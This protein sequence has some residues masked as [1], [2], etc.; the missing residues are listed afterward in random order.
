MSDVHSWCRRNVE[1][2]DQLIETFYSNEPGRDCR[3][4]ITEPSS[5]IRLSGEIEASLSTLRYVLKNKSSLSDLKDLILNADTPDHVYFGPSPSPVTTAASLGGTILQVVKE[6]RKENQYNASV[7]ADSSGLK[8][9]MMHAYSSL[10]LMLQKL[11]RLA[12]ESEDRATKLHSAGLN[13]QILNKAWRVV[14]NNQWL[15]LAG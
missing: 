4:T 13:D 6:I 11:V 3:S 1:A 12:S 8:R 9:E 7:A 14:K 15:V 5:L 2:I 10:A